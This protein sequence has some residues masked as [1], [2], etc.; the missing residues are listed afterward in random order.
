VTADNSF[1]GN[2][3][4]FG[5]SIFFYRLIGIL[6]A[7]RPK[8]ADGI[9]DKELFKEGAPEESRFLVSSD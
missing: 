1:E 8:P 5:H 4:S 3:R 6:G 2:Q 9:G 7:R